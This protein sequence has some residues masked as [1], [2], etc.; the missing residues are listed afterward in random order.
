MSS[1]WLQGQTQQIDDAVCSFFNNVTNHCLARC[2]HRWR[3]R[4]RHG[5]RHRASKDGFTAC[6][7]N[8]EGIARATNRAF[9]Y[10]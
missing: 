6:P 9:D 1:Q 8:G 5:C 3:D 4:W 7:A 2:P 10:S